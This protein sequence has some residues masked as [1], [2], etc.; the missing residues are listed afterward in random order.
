MSRARELLDQHPRGD[1]KLTRLAKECGLSV[2]HFSR[3]FKRSFGS[4]AH[5]YLVQQRVEQ[6]KLLL[7]HSD[8]ELSEI[9]LK[10]G[11][12]DQ[13]AFSR[14]FRSFVGIPPGKWRA[15]RRARKAAIAARDAADLTEQR[16]H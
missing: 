9:G 3:S 4:S 14:T 15:E 13:A 5:H 11:F 8:D 1:V 2:S 10:V 16:S 12:C 7:A 6:A